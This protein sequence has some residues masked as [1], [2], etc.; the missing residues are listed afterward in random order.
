MKSQHENNNESS[1]TMALPETGFVRLP[2]ILHHVPVSKSTW[3]RLVA[4][5]DR[6]PSPVKLSERTTAWRVEDIHKLIDELGK[7]SGNA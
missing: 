4:E 6:Y 1:T 5:D 7:G 2:T 3:W